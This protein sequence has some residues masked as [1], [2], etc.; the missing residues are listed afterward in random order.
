MHSI[1]GILKQERKIKQTRERENEKYIYR[2]IGT[3]QLS[4]HKA[5]IFS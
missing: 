5:Y 2:S 3:N 1:F 4:I